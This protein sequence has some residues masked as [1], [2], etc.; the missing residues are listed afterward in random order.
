MS[1]GCPGLIHVSLH[2]TRNQLYPIP[3]IHLLPLSGARSSTAQNM[4]CLFIF[5]SMHS[6]A[7][8]T[9]AQSILGFVDI[10]KNSLL[11][12]NAQSAV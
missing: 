5:P 2:F 9:P 11:N 4:Q 1:V 10:K 3:F 8:S 12:V 6:G 7:T